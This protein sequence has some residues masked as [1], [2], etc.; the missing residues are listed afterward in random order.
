MLKGRDHTSVHRFLIR[1]FSSR[2]VDDYRARYT[3]PL[4]KRLT[5]RFASEG[6]AELSS[7]LAEHLPAYV[8]C[9]LLGVSIDEI[10]PLS[11]TSK[12]PE[13]VSSICA[14]LA[15]TAGAESGLGRM[16]T[17]ANAQFDIALSFAA[18]FVLMAFALALFYT[19]QSAERRIAP[20]AH[21]SPG[22]IPT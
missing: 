1:H 2:V 15:E 7:A 12:E 17:Q 18:V 16:I 13:K 9:A 10:G 6:R 20:W 8:I 19:L 11:C 22:G 4:V 3:K 5:D 14:V 21:R